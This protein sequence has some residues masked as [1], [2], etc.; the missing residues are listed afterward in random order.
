MDTAESG[1]FHRKFVKFVTLGTFETKFSSL[2]RLYL[3][4]VRVTVRKM[5]LGM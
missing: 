1:F 4:C 5:T 2:E 3:L